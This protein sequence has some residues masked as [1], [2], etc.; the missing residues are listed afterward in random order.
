MIAI[1]LDIDWSPDTIVQSVLSVIDKL[2]IPATLFYTN[3]LKDKAGGSSNFVSMVESRHEIALHPDFQQVSNYVSVWDELLALYPMAKGWRSHNGM[4]GWPIVKS[5]VD[6]GLEYEVF[7]PVFRDY[8]AP[9]F[10]N[11]ALPN[12]RGFSTSFWD[13]HQLHCDTFDWRAK[14][15]PHINL[16]TDPSK[17]IVLGFHPNILYY[18]MKSESDYS[19]RKSHYH[20]PLT[21]FS[22][23]SRQLSGAM[24]LLIDLITSVPTENFC[25]L[26]S[27]NEQNGHDLK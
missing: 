1:T 7:S 24:R 18:D 15:L 4:T 10:V 20:E 25:T 27:F 6:R 14:S 22:F 5:G 16:F 9:S 2:Y 12:Y 13:S 11:L 8:I 3:Y 23:H 21:N 26:G 19:K 17:I